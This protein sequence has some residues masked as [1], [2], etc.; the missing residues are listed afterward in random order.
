MDETLRNGSWLDVSTVLPPSLATADVAQLLDKH[1]GISHEEEGKR[2]QV[3]NGLL[4]S[5]VQ[6][7]LALSCCWL[8]VVLCIVWHIT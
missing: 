2:G 5:A 7:A 8:A 1:C 6:C 4:L 3:G